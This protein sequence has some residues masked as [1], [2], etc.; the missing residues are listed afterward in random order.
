M[1]MEKYVTVE[2]VT[3][4]HEMSLLF[5]DQSAVIETYVPIQ[6]TQNY[7]TYN[8]KQV[9]SFRDSPVSFLYRCEMVLRFRMTAQLGLVQLF[10]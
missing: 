9:S 3:Y 2:C 4:D 10:E 8:Q 1:A 7:H 5:S 6:K